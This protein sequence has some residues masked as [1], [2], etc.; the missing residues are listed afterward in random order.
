MKY[1]QRGTQGCLYCD[2]MCYVNDNY[3]GYIVCPKCWK[4]LGETG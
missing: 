1:N 3:D 4:L 2:N